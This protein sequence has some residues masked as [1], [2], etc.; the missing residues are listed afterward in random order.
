MVSALTAAVVTVLIEY[1][2]KPRLEVRKDRILEAAR[3]RRNVAA[4]LTA[5]RSKLLI[6]VEDTQE[7]QARTEW[8]EPIRQLD[9][10][11]ERLQNDLVLL[12]PFIR[13]RQAIAVIVPVLQARTDCMAL[14]Q[15][16]EAGIAGGHQLE[17]IRIALSELLELI[18]EARR[19]FNVRPLRFMMNPNLL[20]QAAE[21]D[22]AVDQKLRTIKRAPPRE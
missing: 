3:L 22:R 1:F 16:V 11:I 4:Q 9:E 6:Y 8:L 7:G 13:D 5:L 20:R 15:K 2:A 12:G 10:A 19:R 17:P 14:R 21:K 18:G